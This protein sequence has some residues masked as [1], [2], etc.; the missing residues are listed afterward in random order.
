MLPP[1]TE[2]QHEDRAT[3]I[4]GFKDT[5]E[6]KKT[7]MVYWPKSSLSLA[8]SA[9]LVL[10]PPVAD[11]L[12]LVEAGFSLRRSY[13][14]LFAQAALASV[15]KEIDELGPS[16]DINLPGTDVCRRESPLHSQVTLQLDPILALD[17]LAIYEYCQRGNVSRMR[18]RVNQ[19]VTTAMDMSLHN[20]GSECSEAQKRAWWMTVSSNFG[21]FNL[22]AHG[23]CRCMWYTCLQTYISR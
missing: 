18:A 12:N 22:I 5:T 14:Q 23:V 9:L 21:D 8:L 11:P 10:I 19:A 20:L 3:L 7:D 2:P 4:R 6:T 15:E 17:V 16:S 13:A 1:S